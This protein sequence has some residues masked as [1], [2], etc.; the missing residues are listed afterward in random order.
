MKRYHLTQEQQTA[1]AEDLQGLGQQLL[2][3][4]FNTPAEDAAMIRQHAYIK[5]RFDFAQQLLR[6]EFESPQQAQQQAAHPEG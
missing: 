4:Q 6:D 3:F 1:I 2:A 5:G